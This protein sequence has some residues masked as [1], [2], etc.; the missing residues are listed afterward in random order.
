MPNPGAFQG[1]RKEFLLNEKPTYAASVEGGYAIDALALIQRRYFKRWPVSLPH[2]QD[3]SLDLLAAVDDDALDEEYATPCENDM[4]EDEYALAMTVHAEYQRVLK[5]RKAQIKRWMAY[6]Y[7]KDHDMDPND[8]GLN[9]PYRVLLHQLT[10]L[11]EKKPRQKTPANVWRRNHR[12]EVEAELRVRAIAGGIT[13]KQLA[14]LRETVVKDLFKGLPQEEKDEYTAL[15]KEEHLE[16]LAQ[17]EKDMRSAPAKGPADRQRCIQGFVKFMQPIADLVSEATGFMVTVLAGGP[18]PAQGGRLNV[19]SIHAGTTTSDVKMNFGRAERARY[20]KYIV[21]TFGSFLQKCYTPEDCR[22]RALPIDEGFDP[23]EA[24]DLESAGVNFDSLQ[25]SSLPPPCMLPMSMS[26][27]PLPP[28]SLPPAAPSEVNMQPPPLPPLPPAQPLP[29]TNTPTSERP[30]SPSPIPQGSPS[31][32]VSLVH[33]RLPSPVALPP[34][35]PRRLSI[36][37][38][39]TDPGPFLAPSDGPASNSYP[40]PTSS[41]PSQSQSLLVAETTA[42]SSQASSSEPPSASETPGVNTRMKRKAQE[43]GV[44]RRSKRKKG[45]AGK[46]EGKGKGEEEVGNPVE[47]PAGT[48]A[49]ASS[50]LQLFESLDL[51]L[52]LQ[53]NRMQGKWRRLLHAWVAFEE[54]EAWPEKAKVLPAKFRPLAVRDW[55]KRARDTDWRPGRRMLRSVNRD[56]RSGGHHCNLRGGFQTG[57]VGVCC[58]GQRS[59]TGSRSDTQES[60]AS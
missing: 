8:S 41:K 48:P 14:A 36:T 45:G 3:L 57:R 60:T 33:S 38:D 12:D 53:E 22:A 23:L 17:W 54:H 34:P 43:M 15:A 2:D 19:I 1:Q 40:P 4:E 5:F 58:E 44:D 6:Q 7:V 31:P 47:L 27:M 29:T 49:W 37:L 9:N 24:M 28:S 16:V 46:G 18:E 26:P 30:R 51:T 42:V 56:L 35:T 13:R 50:C 25:P 32:P 52:V 20:Q 10:G 21:P 59:T 11:T 39:P 55:I